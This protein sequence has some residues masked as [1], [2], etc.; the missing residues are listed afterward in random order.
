M[1]AH[2][3]SPCAVFLAGALLAGC[4]PISLQM[5]IKQNDLNAVKEFVEGGSSL[6]SLG[7]FKRTPLIA[8]AYYQSPAIVEYLLTREVD[9]NAQDTKGATALTYSAFYGDKRSAELL[10]QAKAALDVKDKKG[11]T[12]LMYAAY[13]G[14]LP[15]VRLL[16]NQG[17]DTKVTDS[18]GIDLL[19]LAAQA[20]QNAVVEYLEKVKSE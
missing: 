8:A 3:W 11:C 17:A 14:H 6:A 5:A 20:K 1:R 9:V 10:V 13:Y 15:I 16:I 19:N 18:K 4:T 2:L 7:S 12:A